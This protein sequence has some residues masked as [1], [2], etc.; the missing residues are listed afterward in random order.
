[1]PAGEDTVRSKILYTLKILWEETD[2]AH[3]M[4]APRLSERLADYGISC[5][6]RTIYTYL[7]QLLEFGFDIVRDKNGAYMASR[8]LELPE[9]KLLVDAVS[10]SKFI[11]NKKSVKIIDSLSELTDIYSRRKLKGQVFVSNRIKTMNES[12]YYNIDTIFESIRENVMISFQYLEWTADKRLVPKRN[13]ESCQVSPWCLIWER[14]RYYLIAYDGAAEKLKHYRVDKMKQIKL[15]EVKR[16][17]RRLFG[18][19]DIS[20]YAT[21]NMAMYN[22][23]KETVN[24]IAD[25]ELAGVIIDKFGTDVWMH[26]KEDGRLSVTVD[27]AVT[28]QFFGWVTSM[29][30]RVRI[31]SPANVAAQYK[32]LLTKCM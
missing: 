32:E 28:D 10:S 19:I 3:P 20:K 26:E 31:A 15:L 27:V 21:E 9:L 22:G 12:I 16:E 6:R 7:D 5:D 11:T 25:A 17:G 30:G 8:L 14:E 29:G 4:S 23:V 2:E 24:L 13:G 18:E 1:M